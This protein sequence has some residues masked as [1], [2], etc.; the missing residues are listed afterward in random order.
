MKNEIEDFAQ[1]VADNK[2][3]ANRLNKVSTSDETFDILK[4]EL[5]AKLLEEPN[6]LNG[7]RF[8]CIGNH[9]YYSQENALIFAAKKGNHAMQK[10]IVQKKAIDIYSKDSSDYSV[11]YIAIERGDLEMV[12]LLIA[13]SANVNGA[14]RSSPNKGKWTPLHFAVFAGNVNIATKLINGGAQV[15][16]QADEGETPLH[17]AACIGNVNMTDLLLKNNANINLKMERKG[18]ALHIAAENN[19][20]SITEL[21]MN[22]G[23][24]IN[25]VTKFEGTPL[26]FAAKAGNVEMAEFLLKKG[27]RIDHTTQ[28]VDSAFHNAVTKNQL[29]MVKFLIGKGVDVNELDSKGG[30]ALSSAALFGCVAMAEL[31]IQEGADINHYRPGLGSIVDII[32]NLYIPAHPKSDMINGLNILGLILQSEQPIK[33]TL[34]AQQSRYII[35]TLKLKPTLVPK[36]SIS[37]SLQSM[38]KALDLAIASNKQH[39]EEEAVKNATAPASSA[40]ATVDKIAESQFH[41]VEVVFN[42]IKNALTDSAAGALLQPSLSSETGVVDLQTLGNLADTPGSDTY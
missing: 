16:N 27:A 37:C 28:H 19:H 39:L 15:N 14:R 2:S 24:D 12:D 25:K 35:E 7:L 20:L 32:C 3:L 13:N 5:E 23:D 41:T 29:K 22:K 6:Y 4:P 1:N 33:Y 17:I 10:F 31:L 8:K 38:Q 36:N 21:L 40:S 30:S 42:D 9:G 26:N 11:L 34:S 18:T